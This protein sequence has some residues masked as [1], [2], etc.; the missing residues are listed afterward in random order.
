M[1]VESNRWKVTSEPV[2]YPV[3]LAEAKDYLR[4]E[5][6]EEDDIITE[7]IRSAVD[8]C[9]QELDLAIMDQEI[10]VKLDAFP[11]SSVIKLPRTNLLSVT[12]FTYNDSNGDS[13]TFTGY[14]ADTFSTPGRVV[15]NDLAWPQTQARA[16]SVTIVYRAGFKE[17]E[18]GGASFVPGAVRQAMMMLITHWYDNRAA[19]VIGSG[20]VSEELQLAVTQLLSKYRVL[21]V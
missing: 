4:V 14:T 13:Q 10:T 8:Y 21:G 5:H 20:I 6:S 3:T 15:R 18:T 17:Y 9:E 11:S 19:I 7:C 16:N 2:D 1:G 12:E